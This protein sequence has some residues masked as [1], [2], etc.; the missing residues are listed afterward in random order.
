MTTFIAVSFAIILF[1]W[2]LWGKM[3]TRVRSRTII[4][5]R[6]TCLEQRELETIDA[7][8]LITCGKNS[9]AWKVI[10]PYHSHR[11]LFIEGRQGKSC[12][13]IYTATV[14]HSL[15]STCVFRFLSCLSFN[16]KR[17]PPY[18]HACLA[19]LLWNR[20]TAANESLSDMSH[21][22]GIYFTT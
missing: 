9:T 17:D 19:S 20:D 6:L 14:R 2:W 8:R 4:S 12:K 3:S 18:T 7:S 13:S 10:E 5:H 16:E 15:L 11:Q 1:D 21:I 22:G